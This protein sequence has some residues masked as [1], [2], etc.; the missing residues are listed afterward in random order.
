[1]MKWFKDILNRIKA[2]H[3][4]MAKFERAMKESGARP[5]LNE[6]NYKKLKKEAEE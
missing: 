2:F 3:K 5:V 1:M 4:E 6:K